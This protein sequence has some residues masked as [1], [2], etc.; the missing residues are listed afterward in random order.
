VNHF[1]LF[2][3]RGAIAACPRFSSLASVLAS[4][5]SAFLGEGPLAADT[6]RWVEKFVELHY[7]YKLSDS[8]RSQL[9][10]LEVL[11]GLCHKVSFSQFFGASCGLC[12]FVCLRSVCTVFYTSYS[13][14]AAT[15]DQLR[16]PE[17]FWS[18]PHSRFP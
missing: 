2:I 17:V 13:L 11:R 18:V 5:L 4:A 3:S 1:N 6:W 16:K 7:N 9:R 15:R 8:A 12:Y 14:L 10:K